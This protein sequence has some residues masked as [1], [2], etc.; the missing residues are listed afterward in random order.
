MNY[1][2]LASF[3]EVEKLKGS[4]KIVFYEIEHHKRFSVPFATFI[5]TLIGVS[6]ASRKTRGGIGIHIAFGILVSFAYILFMQVSL[7]FATNSNLSPM[8]AM[9]IPNILFGILAL[10]LYRL[11]PK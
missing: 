7:T 1:F 4:E 6:L 5:L 2:Q 3:I 10:F 8:L 11:A 9:W